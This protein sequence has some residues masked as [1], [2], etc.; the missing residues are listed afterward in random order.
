MS[1]ADQELIARYRQLVRKITR[2]CL[3]TG[4]S[5]TLSLALPWQPASAAMN[6]ALY[7]KHRGELEELQRYLARRGIKVKRRVLFQGVTEGTVVK[8]GTAAILLGHDDLVLMGTLADE[9]LTESGS[10]LDT[11]GLVE[12]SAERL[13]HDIT[14][15]GCKLGSIPTEVIQ[16]ELELDTTKEL[17]ENK[18]T[19][20]HAPAEEL[21]LQVAVVGVAQAATEKVLDNSLEAPV[22]LTSDSLMEE[23]DTRLDKK[24]EVEGDRAR[25]ARRRGTEP[26]SSRSQE[27]ERDGNIKR[28]TS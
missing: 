1:T 16:G 2:D 19:G 5:S 7:R 17:I 23:I 8:L 22:D 6:I 20:W 24:G 27:A 3:G 12:A 4:I 18:A 25:W 11:K 28:K 9:L 13:D 21:V 26:Q 15:V 10:L 14:N